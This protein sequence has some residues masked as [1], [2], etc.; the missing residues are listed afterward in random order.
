MVNSVTYLRNVNIKSQDSS[1]I[2]AFGRWRV[3]NTET[4]FDCKQLGDNQPLLF[5]DAETSGSGTSSNH[6]ANE[7]ATTIAV[8]GRTT[9]KRVRQTFMRLD[10]KPAKSQLV[11]FS[12]SEFDTSTGITKEVGYFDDNNGIFLRSDEGSVSW[13]RRTY[14]TGSAVDTA[15]AQ[16]SW[17]IDPM[18]GTGPSGVKIDWTKTQIIIIDFEWLGVGRVRCGLVV[19]G[20]IYYTHQFLNTNNLSSVYMS[21]PNLP[22]RYSIENDGTG[23]ADD[24]VHI[25]CSVN[26]EGGLQ[27]NG[28]LHSAHVG[29][30]AVNAN[31]EGTF[32][33]LLGMRLKTTHSGSVVKP[34]TQSTL[35]LTPDE[36]L[37]EIRWNPTVAG[38]FTYADVTD[39]AVQ[40]AVGDTASNPSTNTVTGGE[41]I[42]S[43]YASQDSPV[44]AESDTAR[45]LGLAIDGTRDEVVLCVTPLSPNLDIVGSLMWREF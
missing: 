31:T 5:D 4:M 26:S 16:A 7:A 3:S 8:A 40:I 44:M 28:V 10:Y 25:C 1:S 33:A 12:F 30:N 42:R 22:I 9:G 37:W 2:D 15:I 21:T 20:I 17:N 36:Y 24:F 11:F 27:P 38:T 23:A 14:V 45:H 41:L 39:S 13:M 32:Y 29:V 43:G 35:A 18:D 19:D 34:V 6:S